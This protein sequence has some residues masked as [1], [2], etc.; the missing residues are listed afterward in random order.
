MIACL[1]VILSFSA[2]PMSPVLSLKN[3]VVGHPDKIKKKALKYDKN[4]FPI[5][6]SFYRNYVKSKNNA[7]DSLV[8]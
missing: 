3:K 2:S 1:G 5:L 7:E 4:E 6:R 8:V